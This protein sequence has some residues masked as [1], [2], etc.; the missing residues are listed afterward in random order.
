MKVAKTRNIGVLQLAGQKFT[1]ADYREIV[2]ENHVDLKTRTAIMEIVIVEVNK[3]DVQKAIKAGNIPMYEGLP[4]RLAPKKRDTE[5]NKKI[6]E[7]KGELLTPEMPKV[8]TVEV[9]EKKGVTA[10]AVEEIG[11]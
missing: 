3:S 4:I 8:Q 1:Q 11:D 10:S 5:I 7:I 9:E 2:D 6:T